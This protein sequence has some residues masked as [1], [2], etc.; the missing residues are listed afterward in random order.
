M[1]SNYAPIPS[2]PQEKP[3]ACTTSDDTNELPSS[4]SVRP[5]PG[6]PRVPL[7]ER[8]SDLGTIAD[9][10][11]ENVLSKTNRFLSSREKRDLTSTSQLIAEWHGQVTEIEDDHF[12]A[13]LRGLH[14]DGVAGSNEEAVIPISDLRPDDGFLLTEGAFFRLCISYEIQL[15]GNRRRYTEVIFRRMPAFRRIELEEAK[16][17]AQNISRALRLE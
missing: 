14:G 10:S 7:F 3:S 12:Y 8:I 17:R 6:K 16:Q 11:D 5:A 1:I 4:T 2:Y 15:S 9:P 13:E